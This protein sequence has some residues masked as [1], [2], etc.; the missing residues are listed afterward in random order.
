MGH[1]YQEI[2]LDIPGNFGKALKIKNPRISAGPGDDHLGAVLPGQLSHYG[3]IDLFGLAVY[4]VG[5]GLEQAPGEI[6][7]GTVAQVAAM[8]QVHA[9]DG[10]TRFKEGKIDGHIG[11][12]AGMG[13]HIGVGSPE[14]L[15][16]PA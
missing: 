9:Q 5:N 12:G 2:C 15:F 10:I 1:I 13:L 7:R 14:K 16:D 4:S 6:H 8:R 3:K 11:L